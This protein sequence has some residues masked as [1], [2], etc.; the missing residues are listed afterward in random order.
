M[1]VFWNLLNSSWTLL[2]PH[3]SGF[4]YLKVPK[5]DSDGMKS[6]ASEQQKEETERNA[7][8]K[9][10]RSQERGVWKFEKNHSSHYGSL[11][12]KPT[13]VCFFIVWSLFS[14]NPLVVSWWHSDWTLWGSFTGDGPRACW[15]GGPLAH[16]FENRWCWDVPRLNLTMLRTLHFRC[17]LEQWGC[18]P[19]LAGVSPKHG[20]TRKQVNTAA[21]V[22][23]SSFEQICI[24]LRTILGVKWT[25]PTSKDKAERGDRGSSWASEAPISGDCTTCFLGLFASS[26]SEDKFRRLVLLVWAH[27][28]CLV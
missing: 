25:K 9:D 10:G 21:V 20:Y 3:A 18:T 15:L 27:M 4:K 7:K 24:D 12:P 11:Q 23:L 26:S 19:M 28:P 16:G 1:P 5:F 2:G 22:W 17:W 13:S 6:E 14:M 8:I